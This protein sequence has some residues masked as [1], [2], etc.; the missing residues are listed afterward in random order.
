[1]DGLTE[2]RIVHYVVDPGVHRA[3]IVVNVTGEK[4]DKCDLLVFSIPEDKRGGL[5]LFTNA[6]Y[7]EQKEIDTWHWIEKA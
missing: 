1:M 7:S 4:K 6:N 5:F 3:A 2:G